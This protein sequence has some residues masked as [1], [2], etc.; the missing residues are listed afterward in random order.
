MNTLENLENKFA[1]PI[2]FKG[3]EICFKFHRDQIQNG[4][5]SGHYVLVPQSLYTESSFLVRLFQLDGESKVE[6]ITK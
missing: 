3:R 4:G 1:K 5:F 2:N 6:N